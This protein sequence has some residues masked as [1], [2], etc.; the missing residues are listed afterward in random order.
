MRAKL[1]INELMRLLELSKK[2]MADGLQQEVSEHLRI[3]YPLD[4]SA[5]TSDRRKFLLPSERRFNHYDA[6]L[7]ADRHDLPIILPCASYLASAKGLQHL[8]DTPKVPSTVLLHAGSTSSETRL[9]SALR[10]S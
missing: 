8:L 1:S 10:T 5:Y 6:V 2:Y 4:M 3:L 7:I 9:T